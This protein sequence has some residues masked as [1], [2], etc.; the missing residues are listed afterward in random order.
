[1][2]CLL[3]DL[4]RLSGEEVGR[5]PVLLL[6]ELVEPLLGVERPLLGEVRLAGGRVRALAGPHHECV[7]VDG[8]VVAEALGGREGVRVREAA[9]ALLAAVPVAVPQVGLLPHQ[10]RAVV[11][12]H[13]LLLLGQVDVQVLEK[14]RGEEACL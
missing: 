5:L 6:L 1:M 9:V 8:A 2:H 4:L 13:E 3:A 14:K 12:R 10:A 7:Q 11:E